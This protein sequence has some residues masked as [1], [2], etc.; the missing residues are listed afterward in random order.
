MVTVVGW[1]IGGANTKAVFIRIENGYVKEIKTAL[2]YFPIWKD[3]EKLPN[4]LLKLKEKVSSK[5]KIDA[6]GLT[7]TA[8]L[9]D[10][11]QTKRE[12]VAHR[13]RCGLHTD[14]LDAA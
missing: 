8:E 10:A 4:V 2:Q 14:G 3:R 12:G 5:S 13:M 11:Y 6:V 1:D 9:S 7:M